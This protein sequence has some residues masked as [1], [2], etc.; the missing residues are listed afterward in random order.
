[1]PKKSKREQ[2]KIK[3]IA[4]KVYIPDIDDLIDIDEDNKII[5]IKK[6]E[7]AFA[8]DCTVEEA[9]LYAG[10]SKETYQKLIKENPKLA[11]RFET[12]RNYPILKARKA[13]IDAFE[14]NPKLALDYLERKRGIEFSINNSD[15]K[16][17]NNN[18]IKIKLDFGDRLL[19]KKFNDKKD[20]FIF[21]EQDL[22]EIKD[23]TE[24]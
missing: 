4:D 5:K 14:K 20:N 22:K 13:I 16:S 21:D 15:K 3:L 24:N 6:L 11:N 12:L 19:N 17:I 18:T 8:F 1:M 23:G 2:A 7:E 9:C 10:I